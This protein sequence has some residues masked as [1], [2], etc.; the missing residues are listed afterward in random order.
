MFYITRDEYN[1]IITVS[2]R[3]GLGA[4]EPIP[5]E[6]PEVQEFFSHTFS[7]IA[8][9]KADEREDLH[10]SDLGLIRV[11]EDLMN[12]LIDKDLLKLT[13]LPEKAQQKLLHREKIRA[14]IRR[15]V[16]R[17]IQAQKKQ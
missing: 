3:P 2:K 15:Q 9:E 4:S 16:Q 13:D 12:V 6:H 8:Q 5:A 7:N 14:H 17:Q 11:L 10:R 1:N